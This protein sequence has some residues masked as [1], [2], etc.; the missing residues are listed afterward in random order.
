MQGPSKESFAQLEERNRLQLKRLSLDIKRILAPT[1][2][3]PNGRKAVEYA[4]ALAEHFKAQLTLLNV[5]E[6]PTTIGDSWVFESLID[7]YRKEPQTA[8]NKLC[9]EIK[10]EYPKTDSM[11]RCGVPAEEIVLAAK[12]L[13]IDLIVISTHNYGWFAHSIRGSDAEEILRHASCP[14]LVVRKEEHDFVSI[15]P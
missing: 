8:L 5:Y 15:L 12:E 3:T 13:G 10:K 7:A 4:L 11:L 14:I 6:I 1:D 2:L 9:E